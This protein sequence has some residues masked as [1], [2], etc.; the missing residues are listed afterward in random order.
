MFQQQGAA[1]VGQAGFGALDNVWTLRGR[2]DFNGDGYSDLLWRH[3]DGTLYSCLSGVA[4]DGP[5]KGKR[6][7]VWPTIIAD[8]GWVMKNYP[9]IVAYHMFEKYKPVELPAKPNEDSIRS[10]GKRS[11]IARWG[12]PGIRPNC[13]SGS[14]RTDF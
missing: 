14:G 12:T 8:W 1:I 9:S 3:A 11:S 6:L 4:F 2:G 5:G 13:S 10:R 7:E